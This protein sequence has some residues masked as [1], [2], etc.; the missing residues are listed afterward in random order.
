MR[1]CLARPAQKFEDCSRL[2]A[3]K[4]RIRRL[5]AAVAEAFAIMPDPRGA[6]DEK[7]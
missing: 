7:E 5:G 6:L 2:S 1:R 3:A 4:L